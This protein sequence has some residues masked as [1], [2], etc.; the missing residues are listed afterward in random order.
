MDTVILMVI[1]LFIT[2][3]VLIVTVLFLITRNK[4]NKY[5]KELDK[6]EIEKN[7][8]DSV[9]IVPELTKIEN[10]LNNQKLEAMYN[11]WKDRLDVIRSNQ[12]P[13]ITD[14]LLEADYSLSQ[15][16]YKSTIYKIAKLEM[17]IYKVKTNSDF[18]L[19]EIKEITSSEERNRSL[20]TKLKVEYRELFEKFVK[21][22]ESYGEIAEP[23]ELQFENIAKRFEDFE[24]VMETDEFTEVTGIIKAIDEMIKHMR[25]IIE[26]IPSI[27]LLCTQVLP[28]K[29][30]QVAVEYDKMV[31]EGYPLD[32]LN[33]EYNIEE[34]SKKITDIYER[35]KVLNIEDSVLELKVL[36]EYFDSVFTDYDREKVDKN[37]YD[38]TNKRFVKKL[39]KMN[40][41]VSEMFEQLD[42]IKSVYKLTKDK[43]DVLYQ[44]KEELENINEDYKAL[45]DHTS[46]NTFA[47]SKLTHE[48]EELATRLSVLEESLDSI[49]DN[50]G[51]MRDDEIRA[52]QQLE[53]IKSI[54]KESK[55]KIKEYNLPIIPNNYFVELNEAQVAIKEII[56]EL[57]KKPITIEVLNTRVDTAR[58]LVLK[59]FKTTKEMLKS[60]R[61]AELAIVYG[62][63]YRSEDN[64]LEKYL[65]YAEKLFFKGEYQKSLEISINSL[66]R[67][68]KGIYDKLLNLYSL[69][70]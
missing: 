44:I 9:P 4:N 14:M 10:Y 55:N 48:L 66:N 38:D 32:Y 15:K 26:E 64:D 23:I 53:E 59:L 34:A 30:N 65:T 24:A 7:K 31:E 8:L 3:I 40:K 68:E 11:K 51:N 57:D 12:I 13:K 33:I 50:L 22:K 29:I 28:K 41:I 52:R 36:S 20:I 54:L 25:N 17:E 45:L 43:I 21:E 67:V 16:D 70:K 18:L 60:A 39:S 1:S 58:D 19:N 46:N 69:E 61:F 37:T 6:L 47:Y 63:R 35:S 2:T 49:L 27:V 5:K 56:R 42:E 62:N